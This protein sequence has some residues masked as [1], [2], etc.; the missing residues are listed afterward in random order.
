MGAEIRYR[1]AWERKDG[2]WNAV[3]CPKTPTGGAEGGGDMAEHGPNGPV[4]YAGRA[5][6]ATVAAILCALGL[7][8]ACQD[9]RYSR[10][11]GPPEPVSTLF[12]S[13]Y[14]CDGTPE[15]CTIKIIESD[16]RLERW[17]PDPDC[18]GIPDGSGC[19][20]FEYDEAGRIIAAQVDQ[21]CDGTVDGLSY[22]ARYDAQGRLLSQSFDTDFDG[23]P[24][25]QC[26]RWVYGPDGAQLEREVDQGCDGV[27]EDCAWHTHDGQGRLIGTVYGQGQGCTQRHCI[28][29]E[30]SEGGDVR[31]TT[32]DLGCDQEPETCWHHFFDAQ[33]RDMGSQEYPGCGQEQR[34]CRL[35]LY[36]EQGPGFWTGFDHDCDGFLD[37]CLVTNR[38]P[39]NVRP[40]TSIIQQRDFDCDGQADLICHAEERNAAG[41]IT[42]SLIDFACDGQSPTCSRYQYDSQGRLIASGVDIGC[43]DGLDQECTSISHNIPASP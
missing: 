17:E 10:Y 32:S 7:L 3:C 34:N 42:L 29:Y 9:I 2:L 16:G 39:E 33:G 31:I 30:H 25:D 35:N 21:D 11:K 38:A 28:T 12:A 41:D 43:D 23:T 8:S 19:Q 26:E 13:D 20:A 22:T 37:E 15:S 18:D 27:P 4:F 1:S 24:D 40:G 36:D 14:D 6:L 5:R